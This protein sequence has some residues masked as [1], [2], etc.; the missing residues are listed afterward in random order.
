MSGAASGGW[1]V[2]RIRDVDTS[3]REK[4]AS[5]TDISTSRWL[6]KTTSLEGNEN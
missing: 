4:A 1:L 6:L 3:G 2:S 5:N